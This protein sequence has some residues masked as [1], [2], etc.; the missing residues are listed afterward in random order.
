MVARLL[1]S[2][3]NQQWPKQC[4]VHSGTPLS[5]RGERMKTCILMASISSKTCCKRITQI[6]SN[7]HLLIGACRALGHWI[8]RSWIVIECTN[9][10]QVVVQS[11]LHTVL[12]SQHFTGHERVEDGSAGQWHAE[13]KAEEPPIFCWFIKLRTD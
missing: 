7:C 4:F 2:S 9:V 3:S 11:N 1:Y 6:A 13:V 5:C 10:F 8:Q 12:L